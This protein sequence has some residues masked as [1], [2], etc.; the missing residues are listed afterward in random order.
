V[1]D[2]AF[3][4]PVLAALPDHT[5]TLV[6][7]FA[8]DVLTLCTALAVLTKPVQPDPD[9]ADLETVQALGT[10]AG[11]DVQPADHFVEVVGFGVRLGSTISRSQ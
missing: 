10:E 8:A 7:W 3:G 4:Q 11:H 9:V 6:V 5:T 1:L 2:R